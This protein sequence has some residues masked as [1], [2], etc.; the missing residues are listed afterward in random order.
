MPN[1][2][3]YDGWPDG[4]NN[5]RDA[6]ELQITQLR[7][8]VNFDVLDNGDIH[9][10]RGRTQVYAGTPVPRTLY[11]NGNRVLFV[12]SGHLWELV[13][14]ID[15]TWDRMLVRLNVGNH[16]MTY[17]DV[18]GDIYWSNRVQT[19]IVDYDGRDLPWGLRA[20]VEQPTVTPAS[21]GGQLIAGRYQVAIT[22]L[23]AYGQE[24]GTEIAA[25]V[26]VAS[27][28]GS[29]LIT[30][31]PTPVDGTMIQVYCSTPNGEGLYRV[32]RAVPGAPQYR[33]TEV[34]NNFGMRLTTQFGDKPPAG[35][36]LEYHNG[37]IYI[38]DGNVVWFTDPLRYGLVRFATNFMMYPER[39]T[40]MKAVADGM[41]ICADK[42]YWVSGI[43]TQ[44]YQQVEVLPFGAVFGTGISLPES[45]NV[46][47]FSPEGLIVA[48]LQ[49]QVTAV[50]DDRSAVST[51]QNGAML[52]RKSKGMRQ[53]L[54][55]LGTGVQ[56]D[57][58]APDYVALETSRR[59][60]AI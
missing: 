46:A 59:G 53:F 52:F 21:A 23:D 15:G 48:G 56:S 14:D 58:L 41:F 18:N 24:S 2:A 26:D 25:V 9:R 60:S 22:F 3:K 28:G 1:Y 5:I 12:E 16:P 47:W 33:I 32:G 38:A 37:R 6:T 45:D 13:Q 36:V 8:C 49:A 51:F 11:S 40:V 17:L 39:V 4:E 43:D 10:R 29:I 31:L 42:T 7:R 54:A 50:Q 34:S 27:D 19:G 55:T 44:D 35:D 20:P 57:F 30:D